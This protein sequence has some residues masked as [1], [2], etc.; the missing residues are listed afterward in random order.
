MQFDYD[1]TLIELKIIPDRTHQASLL[2]YFDKTKSS[3]RR[4]FLN[5]IITEPKT[6]LQEIYSTQKLLKHSGFDIAS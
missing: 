5:K 4:A 3:G 1:H 6:S 2:N